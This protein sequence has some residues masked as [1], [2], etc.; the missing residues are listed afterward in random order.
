MLNPAEVYER[1]VREGDV[2]AD[3]LEAAELLEETKSSVLAELMSGLEGSMA[4]REMEARRNQK[5]KD[6]VTSMV[7]ARKSAN[8]AKVRF[9]AAKTWAELLRTKNAND[10]VT[11]RSAP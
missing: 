2:W 10:R 8:R 1:L 6:H 3:A 11:L 5:Y 9:D 4:S 7:K